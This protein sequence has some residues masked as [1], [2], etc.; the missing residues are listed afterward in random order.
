MCVIQQRELIIYTAAV[1]KISTLRCDDHPLCAF[2]QNATERVIRGCAAVLCV[3]VI[4]CVC[5][6]GQVREHNQDDTGR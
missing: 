6:S 2:R 1:G 4:E 3:S 5:L